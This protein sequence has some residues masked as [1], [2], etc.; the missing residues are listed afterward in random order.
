MIGPVVDTL[1]KQRVQPGQ[2]RDRAVQLPVLPGAV[3]A[4]PKTG[5]A[6]RNLASVSKPS[7]NSDMIRNIRQVSSAASRANA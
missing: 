1:A 3:R 4:E 6:G 2:E 5:T 7:T